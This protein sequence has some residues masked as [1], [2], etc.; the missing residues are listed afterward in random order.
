M[1]V[2]DNY[3]VHYRI[4]KFLAANNNPWISKMM[5]FKERA[6][7]LAPFIDLE[8]QLRKQS[9]ENSIHFNR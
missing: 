1:R 2:M 9:R 7:K 5:K 6:E 8:F 4:L 3:N